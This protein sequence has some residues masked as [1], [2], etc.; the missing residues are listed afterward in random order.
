[1][2][3]NKSKILMKNFPSTPDFFCFPIFFLFR[4]KNFGPGPHL[5]FS[6]SQLVLDYTQF[7]LEL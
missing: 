3:R 7:V 6:Y 5:N 1:M 4:V 2:E